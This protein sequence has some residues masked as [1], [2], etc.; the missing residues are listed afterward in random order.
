MAKADWWGMSGPVKSHVFL[1]VEHKLR[2]EARGPVRAYIIRFFHVVKSLELH[3]HWLFANM[4]YPA[5][6]ATHRL[7]MGF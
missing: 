3:I 4:E 7:A 5:K 1:L 6:A 2:L